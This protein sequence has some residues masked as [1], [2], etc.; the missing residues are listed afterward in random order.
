MSGTDAVVLKRDKCTFYKKALTAS[1]LGANLTVV[2][3][4]DD[5]L[6]RT[7]VMA[8]S[9]CSAVVPGVCVYVHTYVCVSPTTGGHILLF[10]HWCETRV[11]GLVPSGHAATGIIMNQELSSAKVLIL[12][13]GCC[14]VVQLIHPY[15]SSFVFGYSSKLYI[16]W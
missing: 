10:A 15:L 1:H 2:V 3:N 13:M 7:Y 11:G 4:T 9:A 14:L 5:T 6:V 8:Y 16:H 12:M